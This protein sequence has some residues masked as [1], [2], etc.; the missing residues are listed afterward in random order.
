MSS[1][2]S[3]NQ[4]EE[5]A[6]IIAELK[7]NSVFVTT[8]NDIDLLALNGYGAKQFKPLV[9]TK[10]QRIDAG[11][12]DEFDDN[13]SEYQSKTQPAPAPAPAPTE[14]E[15]EVQ[16]NGPV[17]LFDEEAFYLFHQG[18]IGLITPDNA[19]V[20]LTMLWTK[21]IEKNS[22][23]PLKYKVYEYFR[24]KDFVVK[25]GIHFGLDYSIYQTLPTLCHSEMCVIVVDGLK[26]RTLEDM[27]SGRVSNSGQIGWRHLCTLTRVMPDVMK[28]LGLCYV[29]PK[30]D[31][32]DD[33]DNDNDNNK[34]EK[35]LDYIF[36]LKGVPSLDYS[37]PA[38]IE[39]MEVRVVTALVRRLLIQP[40]GHYQTIGDIQ[41]KYR[42]KSILK[43]A[44]QAQTVRKKRKKRRDHTE[45]REKKASKH[46]A[47]WKALMRTN[48]D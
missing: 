24:S 3:R 38:C 14:S 35:D 22:N 1:S 45:V 19:N 21:F 25:T 48:G 18:R 23:F 2:S 28:L 40:D 9:L 26:P 47:H 6:L 12:E 7:Y 41:D 11:L 4:D 37:T 17:M 29:L 15:E 46:K 32:D 10:R 16:A 39:K 27:E 5:P 42:S 20:T 33:D 13:N 8:Q 31:D 30:S 44:R 36:G 43:V 34:E